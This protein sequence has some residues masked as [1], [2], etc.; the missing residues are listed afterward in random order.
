MS[1]RIERQ[2]GSALILVM[3][4]LVLLSIVGTAFVML[5]RIEMRATRNFSDDAEARLLAMDALAYCL[6]H[7][8]WVP[9]STNDPTQGIRDTTTIGGL[10][11]AFFTYPLADFAGNAHARFAILKNAIGPRI[12]I[13]QTGFYDG[14]PATAVQA[15]NEGTTPNEIALERAIA[16]YINGYL[17]PMG[18]AAP[19]VSDT[20]SDGVTDND[21]VAREIARRI[22]NHRYGQPVPI[23]GPYQPGNSANTKPG[24][25]VIDDDRF[26]ADTN[27][28]TNPLGAAPGGKNPFDVASW[29]GSYT[30]LGP[31]PA[32]YRLNWRDD[33]A[34]DGIDNNGNGEVDEV[35][36]TV[37]DPMEFNQFYKSWGLLPPPWPANDDLPFDSS[38]LLVI[39]TNTGTA[40][41]KEII[42]D[43]CKA[44][45]PTQGYPGYDATAIP[46]GV[47]YFE[48]MRGILTTY[49]R[50]FIGDQCALNGLNILPPAP[51]DPDFGNPVKMA[52]LAADRAAFTAAMAGALEGAGVDK[53]TATD[54]AWQVLA[55][56]TDY[57]DSDVD[58]LGNPGWDP[59]GNTLPR[60]ILTVL[61][62]PVGWNAAAGDDTNGNGVPDPGEPH[63][64]TY[65]GNE[66]Q[67]YLNEFWF[68]NRGN[69][70]FDNDGD[71][72][73]DN[74][75]NKLPVADPP[76]YEVGR[77]GYFMELTNH[78]ATD[79]T[80]FN[81]P[82]AGTAT[83]DWYVRVLDPAGSVKYGPFRMSAAKQWVG[84]AWQASAGTA[85]VRVP[86]GG[87]LIIEN[88]DYAASDNAQLI[89]NGLRPLPDPRVAFPGA[90]SLRPGTNLVNLD[91][92]DADKIWEPGD[93]VELVY[94][95]D[96]DGAGALP[97]DE[98]VVDRQQLPVM[99]DYGSPGAGA[100][101]MAP[102]YER[103]DPRMSMTPRPSAFGAFA[104]GTLLLPSYGYLAAENALPGTGGDAEHNTIGRVN[105]NGLDEAPDDP[106]DG[107]YD[108]GK[109]PPVPPPA[110]QR[111]YDDLVDI[112]NNPHW[113]FANVGALG[114]LLL[115]GPMPPNASVY[116][117]DAANDW[118]YLNS[119]YTWWKTTPPEQ[120]PLDA[121]KV[122]FIDAA[123]GTNNPNQNAASVF[124]KFTAFAPQ[125]DG[126]DNDGNW[127]P[128]YDANGDLG[129]SP[130][131]GYV[132][133]ANEVYVYGRI[134]VNDPDNGSL[135]YVLS[136]LPYARY[137][138]ATFTGPAGGPVTDF[139]VTVSETAP[140]TLPS[141]L[142]ARASEGGE[143]TTRRRFFET[144]LKPVLPA[145]GRFGADTED[146]EQQLV[147]GA[148][149]R[150]T[151]YEWNTLQRPP[152]TE[153]P[154]LTQHMFILP[155]PGAAPIDGG[156]L[157]VDEKSE[158]DYAVG[159]LMNS[160]TLSSELPPELAANSANAGIVTYYITVQIT[161]G[162]DVDGLRPDG[163][164][165]AQPDWNDS[166]VQVRAEKRI[167]A[168]VNTALP[169]TDPKRVMVFNWPTKGNY[170]Q[171]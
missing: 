33:P 103:Q 48:Y 154:A 44:W 135:A 97:A 132:D 138:N 30:S 65:H 27:D 108:L 142:K 171:Q 153:Y 75:P 147:G 157:L 116:G 120:F 131:D 17:A 58:S 148:P 96:P 25:D 62:R 128:A 35:G 10:Y 47:D 59:P 34:R 113:K 22:V 121:K 109:T 144:V 46:P 52:K 63:T 14:L 69:D 117:W 39:A 164:P 38:D 50:D 32:T 137:D 40:P 68:Y 169:S 64:K 161:N 20:N 29:I 134:N 104:K 78:Y 141:I 105:D 152:R 87:Y 7:P 115:V 93:T 43:V 13:N 91:T 88:R 81:N 156:D 140:T 98:A 31:P 82:A 90:G 130:G 11:P 23:G 83:V 66:R 79:I 145:P 110:P 12:N 155:W 73:V 45:A 92:P 19:V 111:L 80:L 133:D 76:P 15:S 124:D 123:T 72:I 118:V 9:P 94:S 159:A 126:K 146:N 100:H 168:I 2:R 36:E 95:Y 170:V 5:M 56:L 125:K 1:R 119:P 85:G 28:S 158:T 139:F 160:I 16:A 163:S 18:I 99:A 37:D 86:A 74:D 129:P 70:R 107:N 42:N 136:A 143:F 6:E 150:N 51:S 165:S 122:N 106:F 4:V 149:R 61:V 162:R 54:A 127:G 53:G 8:N 71:G 101:D 77:N 24:E 112:P 41:I 151:A 167:I 55:N 84:G 166:D 89:A 26:L 67:P 60:G 57:L 21:E 3:G 114:N 49:N 102:S